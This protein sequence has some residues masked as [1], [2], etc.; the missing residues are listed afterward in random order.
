MPRISKKLPPIRKVQVE[1][2][3]KK[4]VARDMLEL[5]NNEKFNRLQQLWAIKREQIITASKN[6]PTSEAW[7]RLAGFDEAAGEAFKWLVYLGED[8]DKA[9]YVNPTEGK[10]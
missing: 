5:T 6:T 3:E 2:V 4:M 8:E 10:E 9:E 7:Y 1:K